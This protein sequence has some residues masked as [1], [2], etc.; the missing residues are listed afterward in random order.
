MSLYQPSSCRRSHTA[1]CSV[2]TGR[3][4]T[5]RTAATTAVR[6]REG[7][8]GGVFFS[9]S[10]GMPHGLSV[11]A[12]TLSRFFFFSSRLVA[13]RQRELSIGARPRLVR[14]PPPPPAPRGETRGPATVFC[15]RSYMPEYKAFPL[16]S[17]LPPAQI[18]QHLLVNFS[19]FFIEVRVSCRSCRAPHTHPCFGQRRLV[20]LLARRACV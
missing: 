3:P 13:A 14:Q 18:L 10:A 7:R 2:R 8:S 4:K 16:L 19:K 1:V 11:A 17:M 12:R 9:L 20:F 5:Q 15:H 6:G